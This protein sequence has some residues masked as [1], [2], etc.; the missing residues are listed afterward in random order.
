MIMNDYE[1][2]DGVCCLPFLF[3]IRSRKLRIRSVLNDFIQ[4][5][6]LAFVNDLRDSSSHRTIHISA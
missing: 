2:C 4:I 5:S 6:F 1:W 3:I